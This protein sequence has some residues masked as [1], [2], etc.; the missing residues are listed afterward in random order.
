MLIALS[1]ASAAFTGLMKF[2]LSLLRQQGIN[3]LV[4][5]DD[6]IIWAETR[7]LCRLALLRSLRLLLSLGFLTNEKKSV[8]V[9]SSS[10]CWL[11]MEI[12][13]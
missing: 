8:L 1:T 10:L 2:H 6:W 5:L 9:T 3:C 13:A 4:Y 7:D 11:G 12:D